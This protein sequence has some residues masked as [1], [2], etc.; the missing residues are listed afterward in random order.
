MIPEL[1]ILWSW[2]TWL[3]TGISEYAVQPWTFYQ[4]LIIAVCFAIAWLLSRRIEP[5]LE[6]RARAIQ[7]YPG[8]FRITVALLRR[9]EWIVFLGLLWAARSIILAN[10]LPSRAYIVSSA[11]ALAFAWLAASVSSRIIRNRTLARLIAVGVFV[12]IAIGILGVRE[13]VNQALDNLA[14]TVGEL[15]ISFLLVIR[16]VVFA[17]LLLW[18]A[19][20]IGQVSEHRIAR[21][22]DLSPSVRVLLGKLLRI[23]LIVVALA[24]AVSAAGIDLTA[25]TVLSGAIGLGLGFGLQKVVSNFVSGIIILSDK[26]IKPG[27]TIELGDT[28]GWIRELHAR[29]VS[30]I[31]RDGREYLIPNEDFIT[32]QVVN[33]SYTD[34]YVRFDVDFGVSYDSDPHEVTRIAIEAASG[35]DRIVAA[36][37]APVCWLTAFGASSLDFKLRFW[38]EDPKEGLTNI[39]GQVLIVLW[40][41]FKEAGINIPF[42]HREIYM[43]TPVETIRREAAD[44]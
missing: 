23:G 19:N 38:I 40:D 27:D 4:L 15:R 41:A 32:Q 35:V 13:E 33:W 12:Y 34:S 26:S 3:W 17:G 10:T 9:S 22:E 28:F 6:R 36:N 5:R 18:L 2:I 20:L 43:R 21:L 7:R 44:K 25:F 16:T 1:E 30:V 8:V 29:Y 37:K 31:T 24:M 11:L 42:P 14:V 39:R